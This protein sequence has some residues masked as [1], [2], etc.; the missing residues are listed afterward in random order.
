METFLTLVL[1]AGRPNSNLRFLRSDLRLP[2]VARRLCALSRLIPGLENKTKLVYRVYIAC[3]PNIKN[4]AHCMGTQPAHCKCVHSFHKNTI[5]IHISRFI[6]LVKQM[7]T[8]LVCSFVFISSH[9]KAIFLIFSR[10]SREPTYPCSSKKRER[11][12]KAHEAPRVKK[13]R[14]I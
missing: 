11:K 6:Y 2:P 3:N 8:Y 13:V 1:A 12:E 14:L 10:F 9:F 4:M 7:Q 5:K